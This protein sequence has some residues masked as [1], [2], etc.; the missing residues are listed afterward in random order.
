MRLLSEKFTRR[1]IAGAFTASLLLAAQA[2]PQYALAHGYK[3]GDLAI[4]HPWSRATPG[5][6]K[7]GGGYLTVTNSGTSPDKLTGGSLSIADHV[8]FHEM[9]MDGGVMRMRPIEGGITISPGETVKFEPNGNHVMFMGLK[10]PLKEGTMV[11]GQ[12]IFEKAGAV[13]VE[14]KVDAIGATGKS[15]DMSGMKGMDHTH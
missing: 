10:E 12:L 1:T 8:E 11:K 3:I 9:K 6:A 13:D 2:V 7:I 5:G 14:Y 4:G 15:G